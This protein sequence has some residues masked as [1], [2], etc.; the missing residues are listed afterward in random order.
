MLGKRHGLLLVQLPPN[1]ERDDDRLDYSLRGL[2]E[3]MRVLVRPAWRRFFA[4]CGTSTR[5]KRC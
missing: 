4:E 2:P 3:W 5:P 1:Q